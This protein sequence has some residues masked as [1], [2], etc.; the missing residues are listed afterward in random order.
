[1]QDK[2]FFSSLRLLCDKNLSLCYCSIA[3]A[4]PVEFST[5]EF[6]TKQ[7]EKSFYKAQPRPE[8]KN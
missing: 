4:L 8:K 2:V 7:D 6:G 1:M 5:G 3:M